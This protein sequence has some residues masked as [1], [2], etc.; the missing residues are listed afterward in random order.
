MEDILS[1]SESDLDG[2]ESPKLFHRRINNCDRRVIIEDSDDSDD[3]ED[4]EVVDCDSLSLSTPTTIPN[5]KNNDSEEL[6]SMFFN[7]CQ[8][9][10]DSP[11]PTNNNN[12]ASFVLTVGS[13]TMDLLSDS[14][15]SFP[16]SA[17][18]PASQTTGSS[19]VLTVGDDT[20]DLLDCDSDQNLSPTF[21][22][23]QT[24]SY[25]VDDDDDDDD[26]DNDNDND[27][28][29]NDNDDTFEA[30]K[31]LSPFQ[32]PL[33]D[34]DDDNDN[35]DSVNDNDDTFE[36]G[37]TLSPF[38]PPLHPS[39]PSPSPVKSIISTT[40]SSTLI[41]IPST[42]SNML[43]QHQKEGVSWLYQRFESRIGGILGDDMGMGKTYQT[44][45]LIFSLFMAKTKIKNALILCPL[46]LVNNWEKEATFLFSSHFSLL[47][48]CS[49]VTVT[50]EMSLAKR[51]KI[52]QAALTSS[53]DRPTLV[54]S[55]YGL[56]GSNSE[57][58]SYNN[59]HFNLKRD[60]YYWNYVVLDEGHKIK[61]QATRQV[62]E[63]SEKTTHAH[64]P[65]KLTRSAQYKACCDICT[66]KTNRLLL[67]GTPIQ[68]NLAELHSVVTWATSG[69]V[70]GIK[71]EFKQKFSEPIENGRK[72]DASVVQ[73][74]RSEQKSTELQ[75]LIIPFLLQRFKDTVFK[76]IL[77]VK[78]ELVVFTHISALQREM[79]TAF[80]ASRSVKDVLNGSV[81]SPLTAISYL[82][83][84]LSHP[85]LI[86]DKAA[87][88]GEENLESDS[89]SDSESESESE[90]K[91]LPAPLSSSSSSSPPAPLDV[92][93]LL[94]QS[95]KLTVLNDLIN[96]L[97][98]SKHR[99]L[100]FSTSTKMLDIIQRVL[101]N[102]VGV[103]M[104]R[105]DGKTKQKLRQTYVDEFNDVEQPNSASVMLL[106]TKGERASFE[107][108]ENASPHN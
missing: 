59:T 5:P 29:V 87:E 33:D 80:L 24:V 34:D 39:S 48:T 68:N 98:K 15:S 23:E 54:I 1:D 38:Q 13:E 12:D 60:Q 75:Q 53:F 17:P 35:D 106:S 65:P 4:S 91:K 56:C 84:L 55:T 74:Q 92:D 107:E 28:S 101:T 66:V 51:T 108:D 45:S 61:N 26:D 14:E 43:Y 73:I 103:K 11:I 76:D 18:A 96:K 62:S 10:G 78:R 86:T 58:F 16:A 47:I 71:K 25:E 41:P 50:S 81:Y 90:D 97:V 88:D 31:T 19:F 46:T 22:A 2:L 32:P 102:G 42:L 49:I 21:D 99:T 82:K 36:A 79:Y 95:A 44:L 63:F 70:L 52:I 85:T 94:L 37:K 30:G 40:S 77:P 100:I 8:V 72:K 105:I 57:R 20:M 93:Q 27:D 64:P 104:L 3:I 69:C 6:R 67:T 89:N 9:V 83:K 7:N